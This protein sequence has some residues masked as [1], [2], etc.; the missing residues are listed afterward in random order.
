MPALTIGSID[1]GYPWWLSY[2]HLPVRIAGLAIGFLGHT[3]KWSRGAMLFVGALI[4][5]SGAALL[6]E[7]F[8]INVNGRTELPTQSF[9]ATGTGRVLDMGAG[10]G[11][12]SI[13]V[14]EARAE[15]A[16]VAR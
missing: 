3:R 5:W 10:T 2:G 11:R 4:L 1:Y 7:R 14:L 16:L 12:S 9:L 13:M 8:V 15:A 6:I